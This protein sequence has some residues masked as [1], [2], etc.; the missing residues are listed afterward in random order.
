MAAL[1]LLLV[2]VPRR[3]RLTY[4]LLS[5]AVVVALFVFRSLSSGLGHGLAWLIGL[6]LAWLV[7]AS[8]RAPNA[9]AST[10]GAER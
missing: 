5:L 3:Y 7:Y 9:A 4:G 6:G 2:R 10:W 8:A 1:G